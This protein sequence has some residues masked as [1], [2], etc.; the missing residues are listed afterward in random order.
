MLQA[1]AGDPMTAP[2]MTTTAAVAVSELPGPVA[3]ADSVAGQVR[4]LRAA[5]RLVEL[6]GSAAALYVSVHPSFTA[7]YPTTLDVQVTYGLVGVSTDERVKDLAKLRSLRE[8][9]AIV[10]GSLD[11]PPRLP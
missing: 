3:T 5:V 7:S 6:V 8:I 10:G 9:A 1:A 11:P 2:T 4:V